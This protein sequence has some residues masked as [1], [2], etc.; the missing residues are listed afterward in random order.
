M[1]LPLARSGERPDQ[2]SQPSQPSTVMPIDLAVPAMI[3]AAASTLFAFKSA[4]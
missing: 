1:A 2:P 3:C 4:I